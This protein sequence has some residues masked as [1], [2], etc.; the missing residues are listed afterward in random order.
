MFASNH[1]KILMDTYESASEIQKSEGLQWYSKANS[2][3]LSLTNRISIPK[4]VGVVASLSPNNKWERNLV[5]AD[6]LIKRPSL[7][8]KVCTFKGNRRKALRILKGNDKEIPDILNGRKIK[9]FYKNILN[10]YDASCNEVTIDLWMFRL[11]NLPNTPKNYEYLKDLIVFYARGLGYKPSD[12]QAILWVTI[13][14]SYNQN[15]GGKHE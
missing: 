6:K 11:F 2:L 3:S 14:D 12:L 10:P 1:Q 9:S 4:R 13:R 7:N 15:R 5:D 8:T